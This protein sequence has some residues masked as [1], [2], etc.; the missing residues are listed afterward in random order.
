MWIPIGSVVQLTKKKYRE[1][2]PSILVGTLLLGEI[3]KQNIMPTGQQN[4]ITEPSWMLRPDLFGL[5]RYFKRDQN[6]PIIPSH[7]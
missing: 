4:P 1:D 5:D 7:L 6:D 3:V 2:V